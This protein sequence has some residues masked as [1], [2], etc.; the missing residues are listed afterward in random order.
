LHNIA[1]VKF[2]QALRVYG[3]FYI[4]NSRICLNLDYKF[5]LVLSTLKCYLND[6]E[7]RL[8]SRLYG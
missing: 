3:W 2:Q 8:G 4:Y 7:S 5:E 6:D 1:T